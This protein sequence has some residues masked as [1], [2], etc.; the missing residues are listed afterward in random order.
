[1]RVRQRKQREEG[2]GRAATRTAAATDINPVM[3]LVVRLLAAAS[4]ADDRIAFTDRALA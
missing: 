3:I 2:E 4:V 1:M